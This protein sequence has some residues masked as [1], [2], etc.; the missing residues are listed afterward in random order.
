VVLPE[1]RF[2]DLGKYTVMAKCVYV[3][4]KVRVFLEYLG[5]AWTRTP[6]WHSEKHAVGHVTRAGAATV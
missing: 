3:P 6:G 5:D 1:R 4:A 2:A